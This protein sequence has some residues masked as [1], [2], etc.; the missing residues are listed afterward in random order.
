[1]A[2]LYNKRNPTNTNTQKLKMV[3]RELN[4]AYQK[5]KCKTFKASSI[6]LETLLKIDN[7]E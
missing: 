6:K 5:N 2:S 4:N 1:M 7:L 3:Q